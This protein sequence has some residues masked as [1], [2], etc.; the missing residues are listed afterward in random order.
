MGVGL[1][2]VS[3]KI[4]NRWGELVFQ[5]DCCCQQSCGWDG[6]LNGIA[7]NNGAFVYLLEGLDINGVEVFSKGTISLIK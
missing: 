6:T 7:V 5:S 3:F 1:Q 2:E 4:F